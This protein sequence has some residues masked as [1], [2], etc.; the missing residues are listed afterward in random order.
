MSWESIGDFEDIIY[1]KRK[2]VAKV[3]INRPEKRNAFRPKTVSEM[4]QAFLD[5]R[6]DS[7]IGVVLVTG[8]GPH[9]D[10][11]YGFCSGGGRGVSGDVG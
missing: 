11:K 10:G 4:Y 1:E 7:T 3:T 8:A 9:T 5:A 6:E 2:G